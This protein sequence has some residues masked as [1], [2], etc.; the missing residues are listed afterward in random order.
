M[1][2]LISFAPLRLGESAFDCEPERHLSQSRKENKPGYLLTFL[3]LL[4]G[5]VFSE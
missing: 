5:D 1:Y 4:G 2:I 3:G